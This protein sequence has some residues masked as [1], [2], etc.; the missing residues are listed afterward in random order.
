M[1]VSLWGYC[2]IALGVAAASVLAERRRDNRS[3]PDKVGFMPWP[4]IFILSL[5]LAAVLAA[6]ALQAR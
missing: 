4:V 5:I 1:Q 2:G 6:M 3:D